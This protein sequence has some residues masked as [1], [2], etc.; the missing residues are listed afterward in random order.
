[1][2]ITQEADYAIRIIYILS[3][4][5]T[6]CDAKT[7]SDI[8]KVPVRFTL[9]ILRKLLQCGLVSSIKGAGGGYILKKQPSEIS[10]KD[11]IEA[12]NGPIQISKCLCD[13]HLCTRVYDKKDECSFHKVFVDINEKLNEDFESV[14]FDQL[15]KEKEKV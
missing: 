4:S 13:E 12:V 3:T 5:G 1:L 10:L 2:R 6:K 8:V 11:V 9:K 7:I 15:I 14:T